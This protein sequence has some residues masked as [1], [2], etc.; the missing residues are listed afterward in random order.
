L[1]SSCEEKIVSETLPIVIR[2]DR[3]TSLLSIFLRSFP[4]VSEPKLVEGL[5]KQNMN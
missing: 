3:G 5:K 1:V 4:V 2:N